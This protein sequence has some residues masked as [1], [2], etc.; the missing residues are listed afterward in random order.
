[1][2]KSLISIGF[3]GLMLAIGAPVLAQQKP[4]TDNM[5]VLRAKLSIDKRLVV[6]ANMAL[7]ETEAK[8]FWPIYEAYQQDLHK[9][10][11]QMAMLIVTYAK[12]LNANAL[13]D[14]KA[15]ALLEQ[16]IAI[17]ETETRLKRSYVPRLAKVLPGIKVARYLQIENKI[18]AIVKY[19]IAGEVPLAP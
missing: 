11:E 17:E 3:V 9:I 1:M 12:A 13:T 19:E 5:Q 4:A 10:N 15:Q 2:R 14:D 8:A 18:R 7:T 16:S 6:A